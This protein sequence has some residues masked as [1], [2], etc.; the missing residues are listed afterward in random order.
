M[1]RMLKWTAAFVALALLLS[2]NSAARADEAKKE[3]GTVS[4][5]VLDKDGQPAPGVQV[6]VLHPFER[7]QRKG[8][9]AKASETKA[10]DAGTGAGAAAQ[11]EKPGK[12]GKGE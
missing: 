3:T 1:Y 10:A 9:A 12:A 2:V 4:G 6:R 8:D 5:T 11:E 7:G